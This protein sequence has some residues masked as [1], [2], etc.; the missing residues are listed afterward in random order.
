MSRAIA[1]DLARRS[2]LGCEGPKRT[3]LGRRRL[4]ASRS[5][6][7]RRGEDAV[8]ETVASREVCRHFRRFRRVDGSRT[9]PPGGNIAAAPCCGQS[10]VNL[11][12]SEV[13]RQ[14]GGR[15][16]KSYAVSWRHNCRRRTPTDPLKATIFSPLRDS[17]GAGTGSYAAIWQHSCRGAEEEMRLSRLLSDSYR[18]MRK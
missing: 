2:S 6:A 13:Y 5:A 12:S 4:L 8:R 18:E 10:T 7:I 11:V 15:Y 14:A 1:T 17:G 9:M 3:A 16:A